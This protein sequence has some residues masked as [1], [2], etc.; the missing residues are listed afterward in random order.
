MD[1]L[2][3]YTL[4]KKGVKEV[5]LKTTGCE[6][7]GLIVML[8]ATTDG[9][10]LPPLLILKRKTLPKSEAFLKDIVIR[11]QEKGW[12]MEVLMLEWLEVIWSRRPGAFLNQPS[13]CALYAFKGHV[14]DSVK[15][16]LQKKKTK[17][18]VIPGGMRSVMQPLDISINK[19]FKDRLT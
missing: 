5:L 13:M 18:V 12:M 19:P 9:R 10:K 14:T 8:A 16:Q 7:L 3:N 17:L 15:D 1:M 2:P 6:K 11:S 4:E